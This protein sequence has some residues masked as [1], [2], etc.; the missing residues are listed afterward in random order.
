MLT[1]EMNALARD[2]AARMVALVEADLARRVQ[3]AITS[4]FLLSRAAPATSVRPPAARKAV[5]SQPVRRQAKMSPKLARTRKL[6]GQ[7]LGA[8]RGLE[9]SQRARVKKV[10]A[11]KGVAAGL[12]LALSLK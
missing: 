4:S 3:G 12:K 9:V 7:Y 6:Q 11:V 8:M 1:P 10:T 2:F 5:A